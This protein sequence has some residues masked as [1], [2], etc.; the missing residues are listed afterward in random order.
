MKAKDFV[1]HD[2]D[3]EFYYI[4]G[5]TQAELLTAS[6]GNKRRK[7]KSRKISNHMMRWMIFHFKWRKTAF[8][9]ELRNL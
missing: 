6:R 1:E 8:L 7:Q 2:S 5:Y 4:A 9:Y 3:D